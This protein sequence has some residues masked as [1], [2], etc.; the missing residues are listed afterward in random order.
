MRFMIK[1]DQAMSPHSRQREPPQNQPKGTPPL[2]AMR[3]GSEKPSAL[4]HD[5]ATGN[6]LQLHDPCWVIRADTPDDVQP[7]LAEGLARGDTA[8]SVC[9]LAYEAA[10]ALDS[11]LCAQLGQGGQPLLWMA[12]FRVLSHMDATALF[13]TDGAGD[14]PSARDPLFGPWEPEMSPADY[15]R[16]FTAVK[17]H[18]AA[19]DA[20]QINLTQRYRAALLE[21]PTHGGLKRLFLRLAARHRCP[22]AAFIDAGD[23]A[24]L[25]LSPETF[26]ERDGHRVRCR[27][28][29]GT[30]PRHSNPAADEQAA[31]TLLA[32]AKE[33]AENR[34]IVDMVRNDLGR[35][36]RTGSVRVPG[37]FSLEHYPTVHQMISEVTAETDVT[38]AA[39]LDA[40]FPPASITGAPKVAA[41]AIIAALESSPRGLYTGTIG[42][43]L[44][45]GRAFWNVAIRTLVV[46]RRAGIAEYGSG[47]GIVWDSLPERELAELRL[48]ASLLA[49]T[50]PQFDLVETMLLQPDGQI[51]LRE[52]HLGRLRES[53]RLLGFRCDEPAL[54]HQLQAA[55]AAAR[56][57]V[58]EPRILRLVLTRAGSVT[59]SSCPLG[60]RPLSQ[61]LRLR[62]AET[63][64]DST[65]ILLRHK[66]SDRQVYQR[67]AGRQAKPG[68][69][70]L[71]F[72]QRAEL[73]EGTFTNIVLAL[74]GRCYTPPVSVGLL[75]GCQ[76]AELLAQGRIAERRLKLADLERATSIWA[77]NSVRGMMRCEL[78]LPR[79]ADD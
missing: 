49:D 51:L 10:A 76:R 60:E 4:I 43:R 65:N 18:L 47:G 26:F 32:S 3:P 71:L 17:A 29:K 1:M 45:S 28:M 77:I 38:D 13:E 72:N 24:V 21:P 78:L 20:Y 69:E 42:T 48:K 2:F 6:W 50:A 11:C 55:V 34:M 27:P 63:P 68:D 19:G 15:A 70:V 30:A 67:A 73:T 25:S 8:A 62:L 9:C 53:A 59:V 46:D 23:F 7:L 74:D 52:R 33:C 54:Q 35:V 79:A 61:P 14:E 39:L 66:T 22:H 56:E 44:G 12:G 5:R 36:A 57:P 41:M 40:L 64:V 16:A 31:R 75:P 58:P 37:L